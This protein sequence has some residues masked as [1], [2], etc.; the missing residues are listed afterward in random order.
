MRVLEY[1]PDALLVEVP[2][3]AAIALAADAR[4]ARLARD[5]VPGAQTVL[6]DGVADPNRAHRWLASWEFH[7]RQSSGELV[8]IAVSYDGPDLAAV[9]DLWGCSTAEVARLHSGVEWV[10]AFGGFAPGFSYL[11]PLRATAALASVPRRAEPRPRVEPGSVGL[12]GLWSG[13][14]PTASPGGWQLIGRTDVVLWDLAR[15]VPSLLPP[16]TRVRFVAR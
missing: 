9:A 10:A 5:I 11:R 14:Y 3:E 1:G 7:P 15:P 8:E 2:D 13:I 12:A 4:A 6:L 16:G